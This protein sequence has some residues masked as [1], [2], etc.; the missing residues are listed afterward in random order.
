MTS[1]MPLLLGCRREGSRAKNKRGEYITCHE[2]VLVKSATML[3]TDPPLLYVIV[4]MSELRSLIESA[5]HGRVELLPGEALFRLGD[6]VINLH[7]VAAG[8]IVLE[9]PSSAGVRLVLQRARTGDVVAEPSI[10]AQT[11][12][13]TAVAVSRAVVLVASASTIQAHVLQHPASLEQLV[14][15]FARQVQTARIRAEI[16]SLR[17]LPER[18][19]VWL[20]LNA[21]ALPPKGDWLALAVD[22]AVSPEAHYRELAKKRKLR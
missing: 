8:A 21:G 14:R 10:F 5:V 20:D 2:G 12:H 1:T 13:C 6:R 22:L 7:L 19:D 9:R 11:Y 18:L 17:R 15:Q 16:L 4:I 3:G